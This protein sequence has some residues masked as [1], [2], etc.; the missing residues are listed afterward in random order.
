MDQLRFL[1]ALFVLSV[2][3][4]FPVAVPPSSAGPSRAPTTYFPQFLDINTATAEQLKALPS[5]GQAEAENIIKG[6]PYQQQE[7]LLQRNIIP[8]TVYQQIK[9]KIAV[10]QK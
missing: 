10:K 8:W 4:L 1:T 9:N 3:P 6:R 7:E 5:I 2:F